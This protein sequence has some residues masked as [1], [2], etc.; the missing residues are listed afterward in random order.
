MTKCW[1]Q[2]EMQEG[3]AAEITMKDMK[4]PVLKDFVAYMYG[5]LEDIAENQLLS[6]FLAAGAHQVLLTQ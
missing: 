5:T 2:S 1:L 4:R 6:L 3:Q